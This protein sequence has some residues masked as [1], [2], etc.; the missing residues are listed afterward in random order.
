MFEKGRESILFHRVTDE[1]SW[2]M[3]LKQHS[4]LHPVLYPV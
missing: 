2:Y 4:V 1:P 3:I